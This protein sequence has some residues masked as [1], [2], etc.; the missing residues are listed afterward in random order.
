MSS[1]TPANASANVAM[2]NALMRNDGSHVLHNRC[3]AHIN[4]LAVR[5]L[6]DVE[7]MDALLAKLQDLICWFRVS[8]SCMLELE[9]DCRTHGVEI[10]KLGQD[11]KT[12]W[13]SVQMILDTI[14]YQFK[15]VQPEQPGEDSGASLQGGD[16]P[17][18]MDDSMEAVMRRHRKR[19]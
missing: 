18:S 19:G 2:M 14:M 6:V 11:Y 16:R 13:S 1:V 9:H 3:A 17:L 12:R 5:V 7:A 15:M 10:F 8:T 4:H